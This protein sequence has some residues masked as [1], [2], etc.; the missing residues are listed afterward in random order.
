MVDNRT[1]RGAVAQQFSPSMWRIKKGSKMQQIILTQKS[2]LAK[3]ISMEILSKE[4]QL[5]A[6]DIDQFQNRHTKNIN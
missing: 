5:I 3:N 6:L 2:D 1:T 4:F